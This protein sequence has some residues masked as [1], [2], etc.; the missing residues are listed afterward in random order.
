MMERHK[1][2]WT[3]PLVYYGAGRVVPDFLVVSIIVTVL[4]NRFPHSSAIVQEL[5]D[6]HCQQQPR[7][8]KIG[9]HFNYQRSKGDAS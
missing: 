6:C 1:D 9:I 3:R 5:S 7:Q 2:V 4:Y 8:V